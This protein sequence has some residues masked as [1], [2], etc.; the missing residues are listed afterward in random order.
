MNSRKYVA[1]VLL[2]V[3]GIALILGNIGLLDMSWLFRLT[4][5]MVMF[6]ISGLFFL[7]YAS[8]RPYGSGMLVPAGL[9]FTLGLT[10]LLGEIFGYR[11][12]WPGF[13][14]APAVGLLLLYLYGP[15]SG[16]LLVPVGTLLT[17]ASICF[18]SELF[19]IWGITWPWFIMAPAVGLF[20]LY[21]SGDQKSVMLLV[22]IVAM[23]AVSMTLFMFT[24]LSFPGFIDMVKYILGGILIL[25]GISVI[26]NKPSRRDHY[27]RGDRI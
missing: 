22:P 26:L 27:S 4:W 14:A 7:G 23:T 16:A 12:F 6:I 3:A 21:I 17:I 11:L 5:P 19:G 13:I 1:G 9:F 24:L 25:G 8:R 10:C 18:I 15:R 2:I 20:L